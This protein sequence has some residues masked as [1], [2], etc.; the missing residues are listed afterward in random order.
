MTKYVMLILIDKRQE[1]AVAVQ[2]V[3]TDHGG[4]IKTR[5]GIHDTSEAGESNAGLLVLELIGDDARRA[6]LQK[7]LD[8][9]SGVKTKLEKMSLES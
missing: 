4:L 2:K 5:L 7:D 1:T 9:I 3:L 8:E 6:Q